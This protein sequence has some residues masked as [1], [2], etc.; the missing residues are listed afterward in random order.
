MSKIHA[1]V[2]AATILAATAFPV[3]AQQPANRIGDETAR[4]MAERLDACEDGLTISDA[5]FEE[6]GSRLRVVCA[7]GAGVDGLSGSL[8]AGAAIAAGVGVIALIALAADGSG[9]S[10]PSTN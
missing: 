4:Q 6:D 1:L 3:M 8:G 10:T 7:R 2:S 5:S 9:S